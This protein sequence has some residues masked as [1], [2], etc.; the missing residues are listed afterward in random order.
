MSTLLTIMSYYNIPLPPP[1]RA[2]D[3]TIIDSSYLG[4][5]N[6]YFKPI[7]NKFYGRWSMMN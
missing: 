6:N 2:N 1:L 7:H 3:I 5:Y 4:H